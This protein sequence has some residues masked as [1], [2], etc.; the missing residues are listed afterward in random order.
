MMMSELRQELNLSGP[1]LRHRR[2]AD[3]VTCGFPSEPTFHDLMVFLVEEIC[4]LLSGLQTV[5]DRG[6]GGRGEVEREGWWGAAVWCFQAEP[7]SPL[8]VGV[9]NLVFSPT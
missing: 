7:S 6:A 4:S 3:K 2:G 1:L 9:S 5:T 8:L